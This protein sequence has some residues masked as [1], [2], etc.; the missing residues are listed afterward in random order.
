[1]QVDVKS[2][3]NFVYKALTS[4]RETAGLPDFLLTPIELVFIAE[5]F[6]KNLA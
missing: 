4:L 5:F 1:M 6:E 3:Y 2:V